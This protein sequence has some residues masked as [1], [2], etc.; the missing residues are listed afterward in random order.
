MLSPKA[1]S[2]PAA[3][4]FP[5]IG[6]EQSDVQTPA[7]G[8]AVS[9]TENSSMP[10]TVRRGSWASVEPRM[11]AQTD[12]V[13]K[14]LLQEKQHTNVVVPADQITNARRFFQS[15]LEKEGKNCL[16]VEDAVAL[17]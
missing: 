15:V 12:P 6:P 1:P 11:P 16:Y 8:L 5:A 17:R 2:S 10:R 4:Q 9:H 3:S 7:S 13:R 14:L